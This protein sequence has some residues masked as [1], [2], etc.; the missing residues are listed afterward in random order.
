MKNPRVS[1]LMPTHN[2]EE[3]IV[4]SINSVINQDYQ[5]W[6]LIIINDHSEETDAIISQFKDNRIKYLHNSGDIGQLNAIN[7]GVP[8]ISG[9]LVTFLHSDDRF[10]SS[11]SLIECVQ[12]FQDITLDGIYSNLR[13][14]NEKGYFTGFLRTVPSV[15][16]NLLN[17]I[18]LLRGS[19]IVSDVFFVTK[20]VF[21]RVVLNNY[22]FWNMPYW[23]FEKTDNKKKIGVNTEKIVDKSTNSLKVLNIKK[24]KPWYDYRVYKNNYIKSE[25]GKF[26]TFNGMLRTTLVLSC[27]FDEFPFS[28]LPRITEYL[29]K[30][31]GFSISRKRKYSGSYFNLVCSVYR[32]IYGEGCISMNTYLKAILDYYQNYP[33]SNEIKIPTELIRNCN[34]WYKGCDAR[35][36]Y[37]DVISEGKMDPLYTYILKHANE[38][39]KTININR[40]EDQSRM[41]DLLKFLNIMARV[42]VI[43]F[44]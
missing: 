15:S 35:R 8:Y 5:N 26:E 16:K 10:N 29:I 38:G 43:D 9:E 31:Y 24:V 4:E 23:F 17:G 21:L 11:S 40:K 33:S 25:V 7:Y 39:F 14:I 30:K 1:I 22:L 36:F 19:N 13:I 20:D 34:N 12:H 2:D 37:L 27:Y 32:G 44:Q 18:F 41:I 6:E 3:T 28:R 42:E